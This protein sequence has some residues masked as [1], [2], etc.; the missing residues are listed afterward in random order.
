[1]RT[2]FPGNIIPANRIDPVA[3][4]IVKYYPL[5]NQ[6]GLPFSAVEQLLRRDDQRREY[7]FGRSKSTRT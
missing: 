1:M 7:Q 3:K 5:P 2:P 4:N 6:P